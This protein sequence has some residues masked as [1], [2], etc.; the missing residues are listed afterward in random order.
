MNYA[1]QQRNPGRHAVGITAVVLLHVVV[2]YA[3][4]TGLARTVIEVVKGPIDVKVIEEIIKKPP[5]PPEVVPPPPKMA[6][7]PPPFIPPPE[8]NIAPPPTPA[9]TISAITQEAPA[10]PQAPVIQKTETPAPQPAVRSARVVCS[11]YMDVMQGIAYPRE[12]IRDGLEGEVVIEFTVSGAGQVKD[13]VIKS[14]SNRVF[15]RSSMAVV[16]ELKCAGQGHDIRVQAP[17]SFKIR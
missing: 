4:V 13:V 8:I 3:L 15:N 6:A 10:G 14:S 1:Q 9:P 5:P 2:I 11:N 7:P 17:I 16:S 12:A